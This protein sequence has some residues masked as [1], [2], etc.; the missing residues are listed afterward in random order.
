MFGFLFFFSFHHTENGPWFGLKT[1]FLWFETVQ[2]WV[3]WNRAVLRYWD[4]RKLNE[5]VVPGQKS[6][7][8]FFILLNSSSRS[9]IRRK[10]FMENRGKF[11][12]RSKFGRVYFWSLE[13]VQEEPCYLNEEERVCMCFNVWLSSLVLPRFFFLT[14]SQGPWRNQIGHWW[15]IFF[16]AILTGFCLLSNFL[17]RCSCDRVF[18][19]RRFYL[20]ASRL[21]GP[22]RFAFWFFHP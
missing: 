17:A 7:N 16:V 20:Y 3:H 21:C 11:L 12:I 13:L 14:P 19:C 10:C 22:C 15:A 2:N 1:Y 6:S 4:G 8:D 5:E 18:V 9:L